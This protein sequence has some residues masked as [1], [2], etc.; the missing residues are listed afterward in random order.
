MSACDKGQQ[1]QLALSLL[2]RLSFAQMQDR[3]HMLQIGDGWLIDD[4]GGYNRYKW[5]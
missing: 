3:W 2:H 5:Y 1:W 4:L